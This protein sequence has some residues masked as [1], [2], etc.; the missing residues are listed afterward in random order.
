MYIEWRLWIKW[1]RK[2]TWLDEWINRTIFILPGWITIKFVFLVL[3]LF[4]LSLFSRRVFVRLTPVINFKPIKINFVSRGRSN[5]FMS[6]NPSRSFKLKE[7]KMFVYAQLCQTCRVNSRL[8]TKKQSLS[9][10]NY[11]M[12][13]VL[14]LLVSFEQGFVVQFEV[15]PVSD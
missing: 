2:K 7:E 8:K 9:T 11:S 13:H 3:F 4:F 14:L 1:N 15:F 10:M 12:C 5:E 6:F